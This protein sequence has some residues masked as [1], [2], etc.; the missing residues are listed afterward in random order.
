MPPICTSPLSMLSSPPSTCSSVL[1]P[2]PDAPTTAT[3]SP[4]STVMSRSR[5]TLTRAPPIW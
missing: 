2:T 4:R 5:S 1:L 3:I